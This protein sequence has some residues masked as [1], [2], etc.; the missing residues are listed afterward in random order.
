MGRRPH[1]AD[2]SYVKSSA[3]VGHRSRKKRR[4]QTPN[5]TS[6]TWCLAESIEVAEVPKLEPNCMG[7]AKV[8]LQFFSNIMKTLAL[9]HMFKGQTAR[10]AHG[11]VKA[12]EGAR[13][14][15]FL[16]PICTGHAKSGLLIFSRN[17]K[18][19]GFGH[20]FQSQISLLAPGPEKSRFSKKSRP[21]LLRK[22]L[23]RSNI[24]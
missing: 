23:L 3:C 21:F 11:L 10:S 9:G 8:E 2:L 1:G 22:A 7:S 17:S 15:L 19:L 16:E 18:T 24:I 14:T 6:C 5:C 4:V 20:F 13:A 12:S